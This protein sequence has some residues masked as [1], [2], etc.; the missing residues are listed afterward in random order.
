MNVKNNLSQAYYNQYKDD[1]FFNNQYDQYRKQLMQ[2]LDNDAPAQAQPV[3]PL[4]AQRSEYT[5][6]DDDAYSQVTSQ[7]S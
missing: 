7:A 5:D 6:R 1:R 3:T 2:E 4:A